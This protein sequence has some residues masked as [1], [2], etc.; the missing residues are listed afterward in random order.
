[1]LFWCKASLVFAAGALGGL[2]KALTAVSF[3]QLGINA[4]LGSQMGR[5]LSA[6][7]VYDHV[8]WGG[9]WGL[10]FLLPTRKLSLYARGALFSL[11]QTLVQLLLMAPQMGHGLLGLKLGLATPFLVAFF[12]LVWGITAATWLGLVAEK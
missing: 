9:L 11:G 6:G 2:V 4:A 3:T 1:M 8:V 5:T 10:L 12:G 7:L